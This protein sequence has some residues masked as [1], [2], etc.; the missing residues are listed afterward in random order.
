MLEDKLWITGDDNFSADIT[1]KELK[2]SLKKFITRYPGSSHHFL[3]L[4]YDRKVVKNSIRL[5]LDKVI[6]IGGEGTVLK[7]KT[8]EDLETVKNIYP[9]VRIFL[10]YFS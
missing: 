1:D 5:D 4:N 3:D 8:T 10:N 7:L 2:E 9:I 6:G